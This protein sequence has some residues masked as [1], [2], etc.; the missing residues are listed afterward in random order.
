MYGKGVR[1]KVTQTDKVGRILKVITDGLVDGKNA[2]IM[3]SLNF[4]RRELWL[5]FEQRLEGLQAS[6]TN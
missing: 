6:A 3:F 1:N 2:I 4:S 5:W